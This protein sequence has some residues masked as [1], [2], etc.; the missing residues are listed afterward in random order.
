MQAEEFPVGNSTPY[1]LKD[2]RLGARKF[3]HLSASVQNWIFCLSK[4]RQMI[5]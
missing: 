5:P 2:Q 3:F 1:T 4:T